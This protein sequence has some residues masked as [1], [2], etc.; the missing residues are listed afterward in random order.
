MSAKKGRLIRTREQFDTEIALT[1]DL[2][3]T[4]QRMAVA[5]GWRVTVRQ[6]LYVAVRIGGTLGRKAFVEYV[7]NEEAWR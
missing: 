7:Q 6:L 3:Q 4:A 5:C 2:F 1:N